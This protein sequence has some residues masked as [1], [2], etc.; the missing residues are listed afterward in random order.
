MWALTKRPISPSQLAKMLEMAPH[1]IRK[2]IKGGDLGY[3]QVFKI[4]KYVSDTLG[5]LNVISKN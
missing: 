3:K 1:S 5:D 4:S 2:F